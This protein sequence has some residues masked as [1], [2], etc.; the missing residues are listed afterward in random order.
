MLHHMSPLKCLK[1]PNREP[2]PTI[3]DMNF[4]EEDDEDDEEYK[5]TVDDINQVDVT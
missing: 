1:V 2:S 3:L 4:N 5:P